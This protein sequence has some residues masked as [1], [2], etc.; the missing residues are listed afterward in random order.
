MLVD[1]I[2]IIVNIACL[3]DIIFFILAL[4]RNTKV[5]KQELK[6]LKDMWSEFEE[7]VKA[8]EID[9]ASYKQGE[10]E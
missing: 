6:I 3:I 10:E 7:Q 2:L 1:I 4:Y 8:V 5:R 9:E